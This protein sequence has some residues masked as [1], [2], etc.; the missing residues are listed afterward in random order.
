MPHHAEARFAD[1]T[2]DPV[3]SQAVLRWTAALTRMQ[4]ARVEADEDG[5][6]QPT[7]LFGGTR[8]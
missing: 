4:R 3:K 5:Y 6:V 2:P 8:L 1:P 7:T